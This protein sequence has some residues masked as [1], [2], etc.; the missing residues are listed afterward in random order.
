MVRTLFSAN[1]WTAMKAVRN[2]LFFFAAMFSCIVTTGQMPVTIEEKALILPTYQVAPP[3]KNPIFYSGRNYQGAQGHIYPLPIY[4]VL[5]DVRKDQSY[6]AVY[7]NNKYLELCI[8]PEMGGRIFSALDKTDQYDF[9]YRQ[10]VIKPALIGMTGAWISG[11]VEWNIPDHHRATSLLPVDY[12]MIDNSDGSKTAW[13]G[14]TELSRGLKWTVGLTVYPGKSY[15]EATVKVFN[16][17]PFIHSFLY[18][19]NVSVHCNANYQVIFPPNTKFG[20]QHAKGEFTSW[21]VGDGIYGGIDRTGVDL[22]WWKNHPNPASIFAWNFKD[23][24]LAGYDFGK[25]A[26]TVHVAN[27][28]IVTGKKFFLWGNNDESEMWEKMLT[29]TDGQYLELMVGAYSDNQPD[30]SWIAP[31]ETRIFKQYWYPVKKIGGVKNANS[32]AAVNLERKSPGSLRVGF[33]TTSAYDHSKV[34]ITGGNKIL[35]EEIVDI[36]PANPYVKEIPVDPA[37]HDTDIRVG[38]WDKDGHELVSYAPVE[39]AKED[40]PQPVERPGPPKDYKTIEELYLTGL[41]IEEFRNALIDPMPYYQ[42][43]LRRDSLDY[44]VNTVMGI[45]CC[46]EG[47]FAEAEKYLRNAISRSTKNYTHP[48]DGEAFYYLGVALQFQ[49]RYAEATDEFWKATWYAGFQSSAFYRMAQ[50]A[51]ISGHYSDALKLAGQSVD[52]NNQNTASL[53]LQAYLLRKT[54]EKDQARVMIMQ[55]EK[56]DKLDNWIESEGRFLESGDNDQIK[57]TEN[58]ITGFR[59]HMCG[60]VQYVLDLANNYGNIGAYDEA[61]YLLELFRNLGEKDSNHPMISY[62]TGYYRLKLGLTDAAIKSFRDASAASPDYCFPSRLEEIDILES[63]VRLNPADARA[64]YYLGNLHYFLNQRDEAVHDWEQSASLDGE[65][66]PVWRN[67]G[68]AYDRTTND[69]KKALAAY[70]QAILLNGQDPRLFAEADQ[71]REKAGIKPEERLSVLLKHKDVLEKRD[72]AITRLVMLYNLTGSYDKALE[73][74]NKRHFH[75]WEGNGSIHDVFEDA[76]LLQGITLLERKQYAKALASFQQAAT[77]PFNLEVGKPAD[78]SGNVRINYYI[79]L[80]YSGL[81]NLALADAYFN[82]AAQYTHHGNPDELSFYKAMALKKLG[83]ASE[84]TLIFDQIRKS[85]TAQL[86]ST[87]GTNFFAKFGNEDQ[88]ESKNGYN[89]YLLGLSYLGDE[90]PR[91]AHDNFQQSVQLDPGQLWAGFMLKRQ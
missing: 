43:A 74:M 71:M 73:I 14:E 67:L 89:Y 13:V 48:K 59:K 2:S 20:A 55:V 56:I 8:L 12:A 3:D 6:Q 46:K 50:L 85:A 39:A 76:C 25:D 29:D 17:T 4:D 31:G 40:K 53:T 18:W 79:A 81:N 52:A 72:D 57:W 83:K 15:V 33:C 68:F 84:A 11:G 1:S 44:R 10:H 30:Y 49:N 63:A 78:E 82:K 58:D 66:S 60:N 75:V 87:D 28:H 51:C 24:F 42:E 23:D 22:S 9:F 21:P 36:D 47:R 35:L 77:Y 41:R 64:W 34:K 38:L 16:P 7:I 19:A 88:R 90:N 54:G 86:N 80:A 61:I 65:F 62:Y 70:D 37:L 32:E 69:L 45:H 26:G 27:H 91:L 5:T